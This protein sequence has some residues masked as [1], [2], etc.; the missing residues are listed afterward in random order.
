MRSAKNQ[1]KCWLMLLLFVYEVCLPTSVQ[2]V[3][4][5]D[6]ESR[7]V[8]R[9]SRKLN[10]DIYFFSDGSNVNCGDNNTYLIREDQCVKDQELLEGNKI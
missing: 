6:N 2:I 7:I 4:T 5:S 8:E 1:R 3:A 10:K 9:V